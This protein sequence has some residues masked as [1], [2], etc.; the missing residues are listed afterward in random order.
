MRAS[1]LSTFVSIPLLQI[2]LYLITIF[3]LSV[4]S[5]FAEEPGSDTTGIVDRIQWLEAENS[6]LAAEMEALKAAISQSVI[7]SEFRT[8]RNHLSGIAQSNHSQQGT[9]NDCTSL[10]IGG[11]KYSSVK[12]SGFFQADTLWSHQEPGNMA[13]IVNG[14][15]LGDI[16]DGA[17]FRRARLAAFGD[18]TDNV[19]YMV[20]FD[21]AFPG[22]PSFMDVYLDIRDLPFGTIRIGQWRQPFGLDNLTSVKELTF[23]E[24][25]LPFAFTPFRQIGVGQFDTNEE[26][27]ITWANSVFRYPTDTFG[28]NVGDNGGYG[29]AG[30][31]TWLAIDCDDQGTLHFGIDYSFVDPANNSLRFQ[32]Q[33]ELFVGE[34]AGA[35]APSGVPNNLPP[36][37]NTG[38][39]SAENYHLFGME[40]GA[41]LGSLHLQ[42]EFQIASVAQTAGPNLTFWGAYAQ[43]A[44]VLTGESKPYNKKAGVYARIVP[45]KSFGRCSGW[46]AW[47]IA[48]R[49]SVIDLTDNNIPGNQLQNLTA[50]LNWYLNKNTKFQLNYIHGLLDSAISGNSNADFFAAR[51][52]VDF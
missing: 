40:G 22:R 20:E 11:G 34:T 28:G 38:T 45:E 43:A 2:L 46:G 26:R 3:D 4:S 35:L 31:F 27:G 42:S 10:K 36:F 5:C 23:L 24:R 16:Q 25:G 6:R 19:N 44:Y 18:V 29:Y 52:Q 12:V 49:W 30:R 21:F 8:S 17:D 32:N 13:A 14:L 48:G 7:T 1:W 9:P 37:V 39:I 15:P 41:T 50:G 51:A 47:E 33:P